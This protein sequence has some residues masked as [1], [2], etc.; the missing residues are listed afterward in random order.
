MSV[1]GARRGASIARRRLSAPLARLTRSSSGQ[2]L[3]SG[4]AWRTAG[5]N[6]PHLV[7]NDYPANRLMTQAEISSLL[8]KCLAMGVRLVRAHTLGVSV[9]PEPYHLVTG[10][11]GTTTP[12]IAY[13]AAVWEVM[14]YAVAAASQRGIYLMVPFTDELAYYHGGKRQWVNFRRPGTVSL[15]GNVR[16]SN[17]S[18]QRWAENYFYYDTQITADFRRYVSDWLNHVNRYTGRAYKDEPAIAIVET[19]NELWTSQ[20]Y[21]T[22]GPDLAAYIKTIA[23]N[24]LV[25][26]GSACDG[27]TL[28]AQ[29]LAA[30][31]FDIM[32]T[33]P[34]S[35]F[36]AATVTSQAI[37]AEDAGKAYVVGEYPW[38]K[39]EAPN[40]EAAVRER[41]NVF[42]AGFWSLQND[43]DL[44]SPNAVYG[45]DDVSLYHP[46]KDATQQAAV[47]RITAHAAAMLPVPA[48]G[49]NRATFSDTF[50]GSG[51]LDAA[52]WETYLSSGSTVARSSGVAAM[53]T[54][55][56]GGFND[57]IT[58]V[59][60]APAAADRTVAFTYTPTNS[61]EW[62][63]RIWLRAQGS[64]AGVDFG[65]HGYIFE[66]ASWG[67]FSVARFDNAGTTYIVGGTG[68]PGYGVGTAINAEFGV[69]G[70]T[71]TARVWT[72]SKTTNRP[73]SPTAQVTDSGVSAAGRLA[74]VFANGGNPSARTATLDDWL[75]S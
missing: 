61:E 50:D 68:I 70:T 75:I 62:Y 32:G 1:R 72:G 6:M 45:T 7:L 33:H 69:V 41:P 73:A 15:D 53:S 43:A 71:V 58:L 22:W 14:D 8:D 37:T 25:A 56:V 55:S 20:D 2:I 42:T 24:V 49:T 27:Q 16:S 34:Y 9:G 12:V 29:H 36:T 17:D 54:G 31:A 44:H 67:G 52:K 46:G 47:T 11:S 10:V 19:G 26:D 30:P 21:P 48:P 3:R 40:I 38:S 35:Q 65:G 74:L 28:I 57:K 23:P 60:K 59:S 13:S 63:T 5:A 4:T 51:A 66:L 39:A 64:G 18:N